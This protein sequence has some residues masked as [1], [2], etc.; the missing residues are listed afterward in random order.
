MTVEDQRVR[1]HAHPCSS[2]PAVFTFAVRSGQAGRW[3]ASSL[4]LIRI[5]PTT[6]LVPFRRTRG[7]ADVPPSTEL[8]TCSALPSDG[9]RDGANHGR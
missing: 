1:G 3:I 8:R 7:L 4:P 6:A 2:Q 9:V 5:P